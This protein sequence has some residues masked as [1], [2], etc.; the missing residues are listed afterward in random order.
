MTQAE[1]MDRRKEHQKYVT[2]YRMWGNRYQTCTLIITQTWKYVIEM[3]TKT[4]AN[5]RS[6]GQ[7]EKTDKNNT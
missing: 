3:R 1:G 7:K 6:A 2:K 4:Y 5:E